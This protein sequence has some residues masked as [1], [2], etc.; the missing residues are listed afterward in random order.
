MFQMDRHNQMFFTIWYGVFHAQRHEITYACGGHPPA[1][2]LTDATRPSSRIQRLKV[3][4]PAVG[5]IPEAVFASGL[6]KVGPFSRLFL[7]SDGV[8]ELVKPD[9]TVLSLEEFVQRLDS[10]SRATASSPDTTI[11]FAESIQN[12]KTFA[13]DLSL[14]E[15]TFPPVDSG[16]PDPGLL[17]TEAG[18]AQ[19]AL[20]TVS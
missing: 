9:G 15:F 17:A 6:V 16:R 2:L 3:P 19:P 20:A 7:F 18:T 12:S 1:I 10:R 8:Y 5:A 11:A 14:V 4:G 13:D